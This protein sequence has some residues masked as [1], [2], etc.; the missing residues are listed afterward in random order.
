MTVLSQIHIANLD[1]NVA[2]EEF[3]TAERYLDVSKKI[4]EQVK[5][6]VLSPLNQSINSLLDK[7]DEHGNMRK[8]NGND[9]KRHLH[10][11]S[12]DYARAINGCDAYVNR[13]HVWLVHIHRQ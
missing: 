7:I 1:Y 11:C 3:E 6:A 2:L 4:T 9:D 12:H 8:C 13:M 5:N 10:M